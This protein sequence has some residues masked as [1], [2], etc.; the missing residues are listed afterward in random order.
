MYLFLK[1]LH[2]GMATLSITGFILRGIW[3]V[4]NSAKLEWRMTRIAPHVIDTVFLVSGIGLILVTRLPVMSQSWLLTKFAA[5]LLY[6][7]LGAVA[8]RHGPTRTVRRTAFVLAILT[9]AYIAAI[10]LTRSPFSWFAYS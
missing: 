6:I 1:Y 4:S 5:L 7:V 9:F 8:L 10:A 3:M 2:L